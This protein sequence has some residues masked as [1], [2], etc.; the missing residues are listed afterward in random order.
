MLSRLFFKLSIAV[1]TLSF[2]HTQY[3]N[4]SSQMCSRYL[5]VFELEEELSVGAMLSSAEFSI[6]YR[7]VSLPVPGTR[8]YRYLVRIAIGT[9]RLR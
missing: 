5:E 6:A 8:R 3:V 1:R 7:Y 4:H 9:P 2:Y